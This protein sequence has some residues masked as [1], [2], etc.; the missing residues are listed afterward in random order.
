[1]PPVRI[2]RRSPYSMSASVSGELR[3]AHAAGQH[4]TVKNLEQLAEVMLPPESTTPTR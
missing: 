4:L 1:M 3:A 2:E